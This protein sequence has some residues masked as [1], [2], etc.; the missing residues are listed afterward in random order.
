[1]YKF[2]RKSCGCDEDVK[3]KVDSKYETWD[4]LVM[5]FQQ[6]LEKCGYVFADGFDMS[7]VLWT[8][9]NE[10]LK[11]EKQDRERNK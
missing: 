2:I 3:H 4:E 6:F 11:K 5:G 8:A 9:H 10:A 7:H 1:M